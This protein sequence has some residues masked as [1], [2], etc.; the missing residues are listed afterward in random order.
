MTVPLELRICDLFPEF[1]ADALI[2][3][4]PFQAA[5]A[6]TTGPLET[7]PDGLNHFLIIIQSDSHEFTSLP[8]YYK[9][10]CINVKKF[11]RANNFYRKRNSP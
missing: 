1:L 2:L 9:G 7:I 8:S 10:F 6:V 4:R 3:L 11:H 5:G